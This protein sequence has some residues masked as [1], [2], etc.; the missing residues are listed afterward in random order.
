ME[1]NY[2]KLGNGQ[3]LLILHGLF[4]SLDNWMSHAKTLSEDFEVWL[5]DQ[6]NHG[7]SPHDSEFDYPSMSNDLLGFIQQ[8]EIKNPILL[9]H[10]MGGKTVMEFSVNYPQMVDKLI[11]VDIAPVKYPVH[12]YTIIEALESIDFDFV[13]SRK[14]ADDNLSNYINNVGIRQFLLKNL[15]WIEKEKLAWRFNLDVIKNEIIPISEFSISDGKYEGNTLFIKGSNSE[16][17][18]PSYAMQIA[19]KFP[20]YDLVEI[21]EAGHWVHAEAPKLFLE[22]IQTFMKD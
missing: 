3:A 19:E 12:H 1:L 17:I 18:L 16:Y 5:I 15:Y 22:A 13:T 4:G 11:V 20:N 14:E 10:S 8:H 21:A 7:Q 6:R 2:K 9:G